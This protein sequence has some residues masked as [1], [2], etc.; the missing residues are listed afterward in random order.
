[1]PLIGRPVYHLAPKGN[2]PLLTRRLALAAPLFLATTYA[3][4]G[5]PAPR[6]PVASIVLT[7]SGATLAPGATLQFG[8]QPLDRNGD[9]ATGGILTW[10]SSRSRVAS[11]TSSGLVTTHTAGTAVVTARYGGK[12]ATATISVAK[13]LPTGTLAAANVGQVNH[14]IV[15]DEWVYWTETSGTFVRLR[16]TPRT[17]GAIYDL[18]S[19]KARTPTAVQVTYVHLKQIGDY[20]YWTRETFGA[21]DHWS[22][23]RVPKAGGPSTEVLPEDVGVEPLLSN[24]WAVSGKYVVASLAA[25][26]RIGLTNNTRFAAYDTEAGTWAPLLQGG[27]GERS[28]HI[29]AATEGNVYLRAVTDQPRVDFLRLDPAGPAN[30]HQ[31]LRAE[32]RRDNRVSVPGTVSDTELFYWTQAG[33][34]ARMM[35]LP[36]A[37]GTPRIV[38][39]GYQGQ[40]LVT[41]G[42]SLY[43]APAQ[44]SV[45]RVP[46][47]GG[48]PTT[49]QRRI[50]SNPPYGGLALDPAG[51]F[52]ARIET[53]NT[54]SI[55]R[56]DK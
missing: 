44:T 45:A 8:A 16:K 19:E 11:I 42:T 54:R 27:Y 24:F 29:L 3:V 38:V 34:A 12:S 4:A 55:V 41:D 39:R 56:I 20:L 50:L 43:W 1:M 31:V 46:V 21:L 51:L 9:P 26:T 28:V 49:L 48:T 14:L 52:L 30:T 13:P 10:T 6:L 5:A 32:A 33:N 15:D 37:G 36:L 25:P 47:A 7:P 40:G 22:I 23:R 2:P 17:G 35:A 18:A 53:G